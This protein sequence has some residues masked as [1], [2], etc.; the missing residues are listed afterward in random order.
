MK[1]I[2]IVAGIWAG[3]TAAA[4]WAGSAVEVYLEGT[5]RQVRVEA[6]D[7]GRDRWMPVA[8]GYPTGNT[9]GWLKMALPEAWADAPLRVLA[10]TQSSPF[11]GQIRS[12]EAA[13]RVQSDSSAI[14][15]MAFM[16]ADAATRESTVEV[17]EADI[18]SWQGTHFFIYNQYRGLQV[19]DVAN[20]A[21]PLWLDAFRYP[22][23]GEDMYALD[24]G[25]VVIIGSGFSG[26]GAEVEIEFLQFDGQRLSHGATVPLGSGQYVDSRRYG[27]FLYVMVR[28]WEQEVHGESTSQRPVMKLHAVALDGPGDRIIETRVFRGS[29][30][31][32]AVMTAQPEGILVCVNQWADTSM[33]WRSRWY[34]DVHVLLP[35]EDGTLEELGTVSLR[36]VVKDKF[37]LRFDGEIL[38][39]LSQETDFSTGAWSP[40]THLENFAIGSNGVEPLGNLLLAPGETLFATRFYGDTIY[41]VT[42]LMVD[43]LFAIDN[44]DPRRPRVMG[45]LKVPG[46]S[47]YIEWVDQWL[48]A[49][50]YEENRMTVSTFDVSDPANMVLRDRIFLSEDSWVGSEAQYDDQA[51]SF[52]PE[53][54]LFMLPF[55]TYLWSSA[56][57]IQA[58]QVISWDETGALQLRGAV[59]HVDVPRRGTMQGDTVVTVSGME[60][61]TT[62]LE[63]PDLPLEGGRAT[64][65]WNASQLHVAGRSLIQLE[66]KP[67]GDGYFRIM[68]ADRPGGSFQIVVTSTDDP[69]RPLAEVPLGEG[70]VIGSH[71]ADGRLTLIQDNAMSREDPWTT[72]KR[73]SLVV[74]V[75]DFTDPLVPAKVSEVPAEVDY[76]G[77]QLHAQAHKGHLVWTNTGN[78]FGYRYFAID[79]IMPGVG[80]RDP[81]YLVTG[82][83]SASGLT[84]VVAH[85]NLPGSDSYY[86]PFS[87]WHWTAPLMLVSVGRGEYIDSPEGQLYQRETVL[88]AIDF[89]EPV[90]PVELAPILLPDDLDGV[91]KIGEGPEH[92]LYFG[93]EAGVRVW[94]WDGANAFEIFRQSLPRTS[95]NAY[96]SATAWVG[97]LLVREA[98]DYSVSP[99]QHHLEFWWHD[100]AASSL[101][102]KGSDALGSD[103]PMDGHALDHLL[104]Q[105]LGSGQVNAYALDPLMGTAE[106][107][108]AQETHLKNGYSYQLEGSVVGEGAVYVPAGL[109]GVERVN[110]PPSTL[111]MSPSPARRQLS[112]TSAWSTVPE[113]RWSVMDRAASGQAGALEKFSWLYRPEGMR[114]VDPAAKDAGDFWRDSQWLGWYAH[115]ADDP[116][117]IQHLEHGYLFTVAT[118]DSQRDGVHLYDAQLGY[119]WTH[120]ATYPWLYRYDGSEWLYYLRGTGL[121][122]K[123]WFSGTRSGWISL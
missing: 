95:E 122:G 104:V 115:A 60:L 42:F 118:E 64:L 24:T 11:A 35:R 103:Y 119:L 81:A 67:S 87:D 30:W 92:Y 16:T 97:P 69:N 43:P 18:W 57:A 79:A 10:S 38:T 34:S 96:A 39:A 50:G 101:V 78:E 59:P 105:S 84:G 1:A 47:N 123:R 75:Y 40:N 63:N 98:S 121:A 20:P 12:A 53:K 107:V 56:E 22:A 19:L 88:H 106:R 71:F 86:A 26:T 89:S 58:M 28:E 100:A 99:A 4:A 8:S 27:D 108:A 65:A 76:V 90:D 110:L 91:A 21:E 9:G 102:L 3:M 46:W 52:F 23:R 31:L 29:G 32:D 113:D 7:A 82:P 36:G 68:A 111:A 120:A 117:W 5:E 74:S 45:E 83:D 55:Q 94:G 66:Q 6:Y 80:A 25:A 33:R 14:P 51:I 77:D 13:Q 15:G 54:R 17:E 2:R 72:P 93:G 41:V 109:Y 114:E 49:I 116:Q 48:F 61:R 37:K 73:Q 112:A 62:D 44:S 85:G 70:V